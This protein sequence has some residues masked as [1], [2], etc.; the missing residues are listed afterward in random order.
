VLVGIYAIAMVL[1]FV[2]VMVVFGGLR[3][4]ERLRAKRTGETDSADVSHRALDRFGPAV[5]AVVDVVYAS[6]IF[7]HF[8]NLAPRAITVF[9]VACAGERVFSCLASDATTMPQPT[10]GLVIAL[11]IYAVGYAMATGAL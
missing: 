8:P 3:D 6:L 11:A 2:V 9:Y 4:I 10:S 5:F 1:H 7:P